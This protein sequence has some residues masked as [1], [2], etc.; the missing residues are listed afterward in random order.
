MEASQNSHK[1][2]RLPTVAPERTPPVK[3]MEVCNRAGTVIGDV[4]HVKELSSG[5][6]FVAIE[7]RPA[8]TARPKNWYKDKELATL[9]F[10]FR[11]ASEAGGPHPTADS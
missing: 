7:S 11:Q 3:G 1:T 2:A 5:E 6:T 10:T 4:V 8:Q 9:G